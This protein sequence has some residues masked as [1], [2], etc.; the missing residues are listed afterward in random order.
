MPLIIPTNELQTNKLHTA[1]QERTTLLDTNKRLLEAKAK[2]EITLQT[3]KSQIS[4]VRFDHVA[5][6]TLCSSLKDLL[7]GF[8]SKLKEG[9]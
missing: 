2:L 1:E 4:K 9:I 6:Q 3:E 8:E 7:A 5:S